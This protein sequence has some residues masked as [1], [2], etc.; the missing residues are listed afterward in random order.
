MA[1]KQEE[2]EKLQ[3]QL[4]NEKFVA[5][6]PPKSVQRVRDRI[7]KLQGELAPKLDP[8]EQRYLAAKECILV[9]AGRIEVVYP[10]KGKEVVMGVQPDLKTAIRLVETLDTALD[11]RD[12]GLLCLFEHGCFEEEKPEPSLLM[13][14]AT[15][16]GY[17]WEAMTPP[18]VTTFFV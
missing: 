5:N 11:P 16:C 1:S 10:I 2:L 12:G 13:V 14:L 4:S 6:A 9:Y 8:W 7:E 3:A 17:L 15:A 18:G